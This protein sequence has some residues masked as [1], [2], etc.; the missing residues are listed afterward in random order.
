[1]EN[2]LKDQNL[3]QMVIDSFGFEWSS[4]DYSDIQCTEALD[5]QFSACCAPNDS[6]F[7]KSKAIPC[8]FG[9]GTT[10]W[11][12]FSQEFSKVYALEPSDRA[13]EI[14]VQKF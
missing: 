14:L 10:F 4:F 13:I 8:N 2:I 12:T 11:F 9:N 6:L 7:D 3:D 5:P 1:M